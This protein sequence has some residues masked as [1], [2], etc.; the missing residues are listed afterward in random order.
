MNLID[1]ILSDYHMHRCGTRFLGEALGGVLPEDN[2]G[3][4]KDAPGVRSQVS[5]SGQHSSAQNQCQPPP[6]HRTDKD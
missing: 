4:P 6:V 2:R 3:C 1:Q 5:S